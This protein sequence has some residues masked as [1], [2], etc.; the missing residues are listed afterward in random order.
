MSLLALLD[1]FTDVTTDFPG[2]SCTSTGDIPTL[3]ILKKATLLGGDFPYRP[4]EGVTRPLPGSTAGMM[5]SV[6]KIFN[7]SPNITFPTS[8]C[9]YFEETERNPNIKKRKEKR[10]K[11]CR[12]MESF[13]SY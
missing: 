13:F 9:V 4:L 1:P 12:K 6:K 10:K 11:N 8:W 7:A 2:L 5:Q 3:F